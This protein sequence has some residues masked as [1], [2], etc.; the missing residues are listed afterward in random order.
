MFMSRGENVSSG[1]RWKHSED[2]ILVETLTEFV[3]KGMNIQ[4]AFPIMPERIPGRTAGACSARW[5]AYLEEIYGGALEIAKRKQ[6]EHA[7]RVVE[8]I[9]DNQGELKIVHTNQPNV[10]VMMPSA[11]DLLINLQK[12]NPVTEMPSKITDIHTAI[13]FLLDM[14]NRFTDME[15]E[16]EQLLEELEKTWNENEQLKLEV[17]ALKGEDSKFSMLQELA[18]KIESVKL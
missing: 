4:E 12:Q 2:L 10:E 5:Y 15:K 17:A 13:A 14:S 11:T 3:S 1:T 8:S 16:N 7:R 18:N 9:I 6:Q